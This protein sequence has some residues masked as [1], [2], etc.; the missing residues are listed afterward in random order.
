MFKSS[1]LHKNLIRYRLS[2]MLF[3]NFQVQF[4][5]EMFKDDKAGLKENSS[6]LKRGRGRP[7]K[8]PIGEKA[9]GYSVKL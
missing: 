8:H 5:P 3:Y 7:R 1:T 2:S 4:K 9:N 6:G